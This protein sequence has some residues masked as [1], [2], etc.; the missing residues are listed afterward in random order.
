MIKRHIKAVA[1]VTLAAVTAIVSSL[2]VPHVF[3]AGGRLYLSPASGSFT[4]GQ[5]FTVSVRMNTSES[6]NA[7]QANLSYATDK[8]EVVGLSYGGSAFDIQAE[9]SVGGGVIKM[10]RGTVSAT[11]GDRLIGAVTFK[12][13]TGTG[14][15]SV[16]FAGGT[17][18]V[19]NGVAVSS[20]TS[21]GSY[22]FYTP[23]APAPAPSAP[24]SGSS[25]S[26]SGSTAKKTPT[27]TTPEAAPSAAPAADTAGPKITGVALSKNKQ[28]A[29]TLIVKT[30]E[31][32]SLTIDY[33]ISKAYGV[34]ASS[35]IAS[36][37]E[38]VLDA[39]YLIPKTTFH[40]RV[41]ASDAAGNRT[42]DANRTLTTPG[43]PFALTVLDKNGKPLSGAVVTID[44]QEVK[45]ASDGRAEFELGLGSKTANIAY[46]DAVILKTYVVTNDT[47]DAAGDSVVKLDV[48]AVASKS[49]PFFVVMA[50]IAVGV[51]AYAVRW[52][53]R[54]RLLG[55]GLR[56]K[57]APTAEA[58]APN[59]GTT[60]MPVNNDPQPE[61]KQS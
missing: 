22:G 35:T 13:R 12:A 33:G 53:L 47:T 44:G 3:A 6:V 42:V 1:I 43:L 46:G 17:Q 11:S 7:V 16:S 45:T 57:V 25:S 23:T 4:A 14:S 15:T 54:S 26:S 8:L 51:A 41:T 28:G 39:K 56:T 60:E 50:V 5:T 55:K 40:F 49:S 34:V 36:S 18:L 19:N 24:T 30:N 2:Q 59:A 52:L 10:G 31:P 61:E 21:G 9:S 29:S 58:T 48:E 32:A 37:H 20:S 27:S 38:V